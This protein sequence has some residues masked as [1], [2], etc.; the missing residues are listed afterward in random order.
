MNNSKTELS[1]K[2]IEKNLEE[3]EEKLIQVKGK[4]NLEE[5]NKRLKKLKEKAAVEGFWDDSQGASKIT[6][7]IGE[8]EKEREQ[9]R[10][11][12]ERLVS[13]QEI[14]SLLQKEK[15][16]SLQGE[17]EKEM[18]SLEK[19][20]ESLVQKTFL[21][22]KYDSG[23]VLLSVHAGQGGTE[24]MDWSEMLERMYLRFCQKRGWQADVIDLVSGEEAGIKSVTLRV[25]GYQAYGWL[26]KEAGTHRLVRLSPFNAQNLRQTS[27]AKVEVMPLIED[28]AELE[29]NPEEIDFEAYKAGGAGGQNVNKVETAV[30]IKHKPTGTVVSC[31]SQRTQDQNRKIALQMLKA[32]LVEIE[33]EKKNAEEQRLKGKNALPSW[34]RQIRSYVL[35]P[36][37]MV[38][39]LRT[40]VESNDPDKVLDGD[41]QVF[42]EAQVK[43][44]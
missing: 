23:G 40:K 6:A 31:Q 7:E 42:I 25:S 22:G 8:I 10:L 16:Q 19:L 41:L 18:V 30:R 2:E 34:G 11:A 14:A 28:E 35:H 27:F 37:K 5:K 4:L 26:K 39:D 17:L 43:L 3:V 29:I 21:S 13:V 1:F 24:A 20:A 12:E 9:L 33:E 32:K 36:Y 15:D 38:K 44:D